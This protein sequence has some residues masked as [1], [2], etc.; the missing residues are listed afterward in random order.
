MLATS[1]GRR[2]AV[3]ASDNARPWPVIGNWDLLDLLGEGRWSRVYRARPANTPAHRPADYAIKVLKPECAADK[4]ALNLLQRESFV[5]SKVANPHVMS[6]LTSHVDRPPFY[7]VLPFA[8]G[9]TVADWL[10]TGKRG[11]HAPSWPPVPHVL[12]IARQAATGL[13]ALHQAGWLHTDLKL[14]NLYVAR[15]GHVTLIDLG[16]ARRLHS[17]ECQAPETLA[18]TM[19]YVSPEMIQ[20]EELQPASDVYS[21]GICLFELLTGRLPFVCDNAADLAAAHLTQVPP[22]PRKLAPHLTPRLV[23]LLK[24]MLAK[25]PARRPAVAELI[26]TLLALEIDTFDERAA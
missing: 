26:E 7:L 8:A 23:R 13:Q 16:L 17:R 2:S 18:G 25:C 15:S 11:A 12:W 20:A 24:R 6:V 19:A 1:L 14:E 5:A 22:E 3:A 21:L 4:L 10:A 9:T